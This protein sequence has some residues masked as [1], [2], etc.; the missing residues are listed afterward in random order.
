[1]TDIDF[2]LKMIKA[3][4]DTRQTDLY[5]LMQDKVM[6]RI[7]YPKPGEKFNPARC[8]HATPPAPPPNA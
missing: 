4:P 2:L 6:R 8:P 7:D 5:L 3:L 1:M